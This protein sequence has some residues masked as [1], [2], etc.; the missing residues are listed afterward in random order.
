MSTIVRQTKTEDIKAAGEVLK[1]GG[2]VAF[3]TDTVYGLGAVFDD[4][5]AV[6]KIFAAKGREEKKPLSILV[7]DIVQ[8]ELL[9]EIKSGEMAQKAERLMKKYWPGALTLIFQ[10]KPGIPDAVTAGGETIGIRMPDMELTRELICAAGKPLAAPSANTSGK[11]SSVSAREVL[12]DLDGKI[13][14]VID[15]GTCPV[16][17]A[18]TVVDMTGDTPVILREG[19]ITAEMIAQA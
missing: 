19:V 1:Q 11:R 3:P 15:G 5:K 17:V 16:G 13:D 10:K 18:S 2:I 12:E 14:M 4:E 7:A 6:R 9:S 8:V